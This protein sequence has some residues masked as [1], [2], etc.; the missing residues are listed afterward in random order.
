VGERG[1]G[2]TADVNVVPSGMNVDADDRTV[3]RAEMKI[4]AAERA[5]LSDARE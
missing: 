4:V 2:D 1:G 5:T 3:L